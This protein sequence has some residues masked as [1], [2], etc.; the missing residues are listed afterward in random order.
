MTDSAAPVAEQPVQL[1][2]EVVHGGKKPPPDPM[3]IWESDTGRARFPVDYSPK[4]VRDALKASGRDP[5]GYKRVDS[6]APSEEDG[7][8]SAASVGRAAGLGARNVIT[9]LSAPIGA[10]GDVLTAAINT[11]TAIYNKVTGSNAASPLP[12]STSQYIQQLLSAAG[13]PE[14]ETTQEHVLGAIESGMAGA[15]GQFAAL[16]ALKS[17]RPP[18]SPILDQLTQNPTAQIIGAATGGAAGAMAQ[19]R[20]AG[21]WGTAGASMIGS[22]LPQ[23]V[24]AALNVAR[25]AAVGNASQADLQNTLGNFQRAGTVP[26][27]GQLGESKFAQGMESNLRRWPGGVGVGLEQKEAQQAGMGVKAKAVAEQL[28]GG[29]VVTPVQAG[30]IIEQGLEGP[31]GFTQ[32]AREAQDLLH[33]DPA[34]APITDVELSNTVDKLTDL[35]TP[36]PGAP[37][38]TGGQQSPVLKAL[39]ED[40]KKD[41]GLKGPLTIPLPGGRFGYLDPATGRV[42]MLPPGSAPPI[43]TALDRT[44]L[45]ALR[46]RMGQRLDSTTMAEDFP[47]AEYR[48]VYGAMSRD[49]EL[50]AMEA[51]MRMSYADP[52]ITNLVARWKA[53]GTVAKSEIEALDRVNQNY[54]NAGQPPI[55]GPAI[56]A[57]RKANKFTEAYHDLVETTLDR[58]KKQKTPEKVW[59]MA[60][61][62]M[63]DGG[64]QIANLFSALRPLEQDAVRS[65]II[66]R[67]GKAKN[68]WQDKIDGSKFSSEALMTRWSDISPEARQV[69]FGNDPDLLRNMNSLAETAAKIRRTKSVG[70]NE[71]GSGGAAISAGAAVAAGEAVLSGKAATF[72]RVTGA[73]SLIWGASKI[74]M[75]SPKFVGWL[76]KTSRLPTSALPTA[77][78]EAVQIANDSNDPQFKADMGKYIGNVNDGL[79]LHAKLEQE[80]PKSTTFLLRDTISRPAP[81]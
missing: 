74:M 44:A 43:G 65:S 39:F 73:F 45:K 58:L 49:L 37:A 15:G 53:G 51:D 59:A 69:L 76:A 47:R 28:G 50:A 19:Q 1:E 35:T 79:R 14:A 66:G 78:N 71:S 40:I 70:A 3:Q 27:V 13:M 18:P 26:T 81:R 52:L 57:M 80:S 34:L 12:T 20:G 25:K 29:N 63:E 46:T 56:T 11:P 61:S 67:L 31:G 62:D 9:G 5:K 8:W 6:G 55:Y 77:L 16:N 21:P 72:F 48:R 4:D 24:P 30:K 7:A 23:G 60:T 38:S 75:Q 17:A 10:A 41:L 42:V 22:V 33:N 54:I 2:T 32:R 36:H 68:G 64:T